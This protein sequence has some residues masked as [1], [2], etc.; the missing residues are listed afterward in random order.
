M[1][2]LFL[3]SYIKKQDTTQTNK[4]PKPNKSPKH[5]ILGNELNQESERLLEG[6][7]YDIEKGKER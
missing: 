5:K 4:K 3:Y 6:K 7:L 1:V 2:I